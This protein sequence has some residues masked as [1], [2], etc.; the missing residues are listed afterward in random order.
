MC[1][2]TAQRNESQVNASCTSS[3]LKVT[4]DLQGYLLENIFFARCREVCSET[5]NSI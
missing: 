5:F 2:R 1:R 3:I 4:V